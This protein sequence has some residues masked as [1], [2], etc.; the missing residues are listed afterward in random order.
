MF[1]F[2]LPSSDGRELNS[3]R[4][5]TFLSFSYY[6]FDVNPKT[7]KFER[8]GVT[9]TIGDQG[10]RSFWNE[11]KKTLPPLDIFIDDGGHTMTQQIVTFEEM[12]PHVKDGGVFLCEDTHTSYWLGQ[13]G[14][15][16]YKKKGT[17]MEFVKD[18]LDSV[19]AYNSKELEK[20]KVGWQPNSG[21]IPVQVFAAARLDVPCLLHEPP[22]FSLQPDDN[23]K[24][25]RGIHVYD[26]MVFFEKLATSPL[27]TIKKGNSWMSYD[28]K[29]EDCKEVGKNGQCIK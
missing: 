22:P 11:V 8:D 5:P 25:I 17:W 20:L 18:L 10:K 16:A 9:I 3:M 6:G 19:N 14:Y 15:G 1:F 12:F 4:P 13:F 28:G 29:E 27:E 26:S 24:H 2:A 21:G 7:K 23:T